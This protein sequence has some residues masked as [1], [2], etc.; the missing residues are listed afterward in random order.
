MNIMRLD[1]NTYIYPFLS[2]SCFFYT[3]VTVLCI[4]QKWGSVSQNFLF[5]RKLKKA[6]CYIHL[7]NWLVSRFFH[8]KFPFSWSHLVWKIENLVT[9]LPPRLRLRWQNC[10]SILIFQTQRL[11][12]NRKIIVSKPFVHTKFDKFM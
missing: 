9:D 4:V 8:Y 3:P 12:E 2:L 1:D 6:F 11:L 10:H 7:T 5:S